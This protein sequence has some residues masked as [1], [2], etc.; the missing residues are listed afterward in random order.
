MLEIL[1]HQRKGVGKKSSN[2][3]NNYVAKSFDQTISAYNSRD[4]KKAKKPQALR[5]WSVC[6]FSG[7]L[8]LSSIYVALN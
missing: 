5:I 6:G 7:K 1:E 8:T 3:K 2:W 4:E